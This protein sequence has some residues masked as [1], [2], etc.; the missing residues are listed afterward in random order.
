MD[1][2]TTGTPGSAFAQLITNL[3]NNASSVVIDGATAGTN[4]MPFAGLMGY[5]SDNSTGPKAYLNVL[6]FDQNYQF[7]PSQSTFKSVT[8]A[9][10][11]TGT[12]VQ[13][14]LVKTIQITIQKPGYV[15]I[16]FSNENPTPVEVFFDDFKVIHT[17]SNIVQKDD[18]YPFG[19]TF[20]S[21]SAPSG[22]QQA[23]KFNG[24]ER[25]ELTGWDDFGARM[26][27]SDLGRWGVV[28]PL[29]AE[30]HDVSPFNYAIN[31]PIRFIDPDGN[32]VWDM[33]TDKAHKSA[34]VTFARTKE[35]KRF[36]AQYAKAGQEIGG[37]R[38]KKDGKYSHQH[39][40][41]YSAANLDGG[42]HGMTR[43]F[44]RTKQSPK[45]LKLTNITPST[46][47]ENKGNLDNLSFSIDIKNGISEN[48]ALLTIGHEAF[49]HVEKT[50]KDVKEGLLKFFSGEFGSGTDG[51]TDF[52]IFMTKLVGDESDHRL[53]VNGEVVSMENFVKELDY[54]FGGNTFFTNYEE[55]KNAEKKRL[56]K[57][58]RR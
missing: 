51:E 23:F 5:G 55:W 34:L 11:E 27:M 19:M 18:Y 14:E 9:A 46:I 49:I 33:T 48:D 57:S 54:L 36:L 56:E 32:S 45:G 3:A 42:A 20:N 12:N 24:K 16:Y 44:L 39:V 6:V 31:N 17:N 25:E 29:A 35:G 26:Y 15:Y 41:F 10:R 30:Y 52:S 7:Q 50:T 58:S 40:A 47:K 53:A 21:Y 37:V 13:H 2:N 4:P 43:A 8:L 22:I 28:D 1:P 38:F